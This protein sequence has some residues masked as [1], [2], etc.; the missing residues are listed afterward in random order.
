M[1]TESASVGGTGEGE[2]GVLQS[3]IRFRPWSKEREQQ[4]QRGMSHV[5]WVSKTTELI[6]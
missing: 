2:G 5:L 6:W 1:A 4:A 3:A